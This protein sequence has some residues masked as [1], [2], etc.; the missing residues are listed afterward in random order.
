MT[1]RVNKI[2]DSNK[3]QATLQPKTTPAPAVKTKSITDRAFDFLRKYTP[4][5]LPLVYGVDYFRRGSFIPAIPTCLAAI[6]IGALNTSMG[7][8]CV[9]E[10]ALWILDGYE[11]SDAYRLGGIELVDILVRRGADVKARQD[12]LKRTLLHTAAEAGDI[13]FM[14]YLIAK[15]LSVNATDEDGRTPLHAAAAKER[16]EAAEFLVKNGAKVDVLDR[17]GVPAFLIACTS[18]SAPFIQTFLSFKP[19][20]RIGNRSVFSFPL[21]SA[22]AI[23]VMLGVKGLKGFDQCVDINDFCN[24]LCPASRDK[25]PA[26]WKALVA[27]APSPKCCEALEKDKKALCARILP[28]DKFIDLFKEDHLESR[29][30]RLCRKLDLQSYIRTLPIKEMILKLEAAN[31]LFAR[32]YHLAGRP[33][34]EYAKGAQEDIEVYYDHPNRTIYL[35]KLLL[36]DYGY[37]SLSLK[38]IVSNLISGM[39]N[40]LF[41]EH[42]NHV[43]SQCSKIPRETYTVYLEWYQSQINYWWNIATSPMLG[44]G[45][46]LYPLTDDKLKNFEITWNKAH[47]KNHWVGDKLT[48]TADSNRFEWALNAD[49]QVIIQAAKAYRQSLTAPPRD[50]KS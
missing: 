20:L 41:R 27:K 40:Y 50:A 22:E 3:P 15:G 36:K 28:F 29:S 13:R 43:K 32:M 48:C 31:P 42:V 5:A 44:N 8:K 4:I 16:A 25:P 33:N 6:T 37:R 39:A 7:K 38:H 35:S 45:K 12:F 2:L 14:R 1:A 21:V 26:N 9:V 11:L 19:N 49:P 30:K 10:S 47:Q 17:D 34:V 23:R 46:P 18:S 24:V